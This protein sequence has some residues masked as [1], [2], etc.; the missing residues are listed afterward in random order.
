MAGHQQME[1][2]QGCLAGLHSGRRGVRWKE[3]VR[4]IEEE[5]PRKTQGQCGGNEACQSSGKS[6]GQRKDSR[7]AK[8]KLKWAARIVQMMFKILNSIYE[9]V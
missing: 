4:E 1:A 7:E 6:K 2:R 8:S 5:K 9:Y 3:E